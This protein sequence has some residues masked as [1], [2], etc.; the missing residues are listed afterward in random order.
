MLVY[1]VCWFEDRPVLSGRGYIDD[2][3][4][5][6]NLPI[7][8]HEFNRFCYRRNLLDEIQDSCYPFHTACLVILQESH[9]KAFFDHDA[10]TLFNIFES[11]HYQRSAR[12]LRWGHNYYFEELLDP[13]SDE[14]D[15]DNLSEDVVPANKAK[16]SILISSLNFEAQNEEAWNQQCLDHLFSSSQVSTRNKG[17]IPTL[18]KIWAGLSLPLSPTSISFSGSICDER[19]GRLDIHCLPNEVLESILCILDFCDTRNLLQAGATLFRRYGG[20]IRNLPTLFWESRFWAHGET[21]FARSIRPSSYSWKNWF[22]RI[23]SGLKEGPNKINLRNRRRTWKLVVDLTDLLYAVQEPNRVL[24]GDSVIPQG[25]ILPGYVASCLAQKYDSEGCRELTHRYVCLDN[26]S[27]LCTVTPSYILFSNR[28]LISGLSFKFH[29]GGYINVGYVVDNPEKRVASMVSPT[30]LWL[31]FSQLGFE[32]ITVDT[33]PQEYLD[34][35]TPSHRT[36][37]AIARWPLKNLKGVHLGLDAMQMV[38][39][40]MDI[41]RQDKFDD[42]FWRH[43][44]LSTTPS[45]HE[46]DVAALYRL[47]NASFAP[48]STHFIDQGKGILIAIKVYLQSLG[49]P[50]PYGVLPTTLLHWHFFSTQITAY[51]IDSLVCQLQFTTNIGRTSNVFPPL[52]IDAIVSYECIEYKVLNGGYIIGFCGCFRAPSS[53]LH[54]FGVVPTTSVTSSKILSKTFVTKL[55]LEG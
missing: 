4:M 46:D 42:I 55:A 50:K 15:P 16:L 29:D 30:C 13:S 2:D 18:Q 7:P 6:I 17:M 23:E 45:I 37:I 28:R 9:G 34:S 40:S 24:C 47:Q 39:I 43:P 48:A 1:L 49:V 35:L 36:K 31:V 22:S 25:Q 14:K 41:E 52:S 5:P 33:Y 26:R 8:L 53:E 11:I 21:G 19:K 12:A 54:C 27:R 32:A 10:Q 20:D 51:K 38:K 3:A 44:R